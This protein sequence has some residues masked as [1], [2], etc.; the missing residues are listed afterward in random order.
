[1]TIAL[2]PNARDIPFALLYLAE[3]NLSETPKLHGQ[4]RVLSGAPAT[5]DEFAGPMGLQTRQVPVPPALVL[6]SDVSVRPDWAMVIP[7]LANA[8]EGKLSPA[9]QG[10]RPTFVTD[11]RTLPAY[12]RA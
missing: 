3:D 11:G 10:T 12:S 6:T 7:L 2:S 9:P 4:V 8:S 1:M 5:V